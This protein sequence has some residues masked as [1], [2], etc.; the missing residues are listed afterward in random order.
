MTLS[1]IIPTFNEA[2]V[3]GRLVQ[4]LLL[5]SSEGTEILVADGGSTDM[6]QRIA[7]ASGAKVVN[8][9]CKGRAPQMNKAASGATG[10]VLYFLHADTFPPVQFEKQIKG[11][12]E[13]GFG[14]GCFRLQFDDPHWFLSLNAWFTRFDLDAVRFGD[15]SLFVKKELFELAG[16]F[17]EKL[18]LLEDQ[19]IITR[20]RKQQPFV[21]LPQAVVTSARKYKEVG[22]YTLQTGY[23]LI[24]TLYRMGV[25]Q[26]RLVQVYR[27]LLTK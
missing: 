3:I 8:C 5:H 25:S 21:V 23:F 16:G 18:I 11:A 10:N 20:L 26:R 12:V 9:A 6:T 15:Q 24:Y 1:I 7:T 14:S 27:W 22:V 2:A 19:E 4:Y 13:N 17:D